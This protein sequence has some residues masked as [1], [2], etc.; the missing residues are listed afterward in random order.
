MS[1]SSRLL[2][3]SKCQPEDPWNTP[4]DITS[5]LIAGL[6]PYNA[7]LVW[8]NHSVLVCHSCR[9]IP[10]V[11]TYPKMPLWYLALDIQRREELLP[12][13]AMCRWVKNHSLFTWWKLSLLVF[14][15]IIKGL[16]HTHK[17]LA[18]DIPLRAR[19]YQPEA[20]VSSWLKIR[21][22]GLISGCLLIPPD[23]N[24]LN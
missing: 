10:A 14:P 5:P 11:G 21:I 20:A 22:W 4:R 3:K 16:S 7:L 18:G 23:D 19:S 13:R 9:G 1:H 2:S 17:P 15:V 6:L 24:E 12:T 8:K